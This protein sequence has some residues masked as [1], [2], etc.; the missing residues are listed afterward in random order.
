ML[1]AMLSNPG[2]IPQQN[3]YF[4]TGPPGALPLSALTLEL[5]KFIEIPINGAQIRLKFCK[6]CHIL[7][8]PRASHCSF[9]GVC[10]ERFDHHC[11]WI[12]NCIGKKNYLLFVVFLW[13]LTLNQGFMWGICLLHILKNKQKR[14]NLRETLN[15]E[16]PEMVLGAYSVLVK[17]YIGFR[18]CRLFEP[19]SPV[20]NLQK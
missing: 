16:V 15:H 7:R 6:T 3:A 1:A 5:P 17:D 14:E 20:S 10:V 4:S 2:F 9:C 8:P 13:V 11:P 19:F 12:G 18:V